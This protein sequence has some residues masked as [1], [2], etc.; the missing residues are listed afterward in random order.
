MAATKR[1]YRSDDVAVAGVCAGIAEHLDMDVAAVRI[2]AILLFFA[3]FGLVAVVYSFLWLVL[4]KHVAISSETLPCAAYS[5][6]GSEVF[7]CD[8]GDPCC[9]A[10]P[11]GWS[12]ACM[13]VGIALLTVGVAFLLAA[14]VRGVSWW[15]FLPI[16]VCLTGV[17]LMVTPSRSM[18]RLRRFSLGLMLLFFGL[19]ILAVSVGVVDARTVLFA[20]S[21]LWPGG[22]VV[23]GLVIIGSA[24]DDDLFYLGAA[25]CLAVLLLA[26][27]FGFADPMPL[28]VSGVML[29]GAPAAPT[30]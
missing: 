28:E 5:D 10:G 15:R 12:R 20:A 30:F 22:L 18:P 8:S 4:P 11:A 13:W 1:I 3:S 21:K 6:E 9:S 25:A 29:S 16:A 19:L 26:A 23:V 17:A 7:P 2:L 27:T 24:L 14:F